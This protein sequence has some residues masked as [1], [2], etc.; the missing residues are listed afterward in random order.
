MIAS[1]RLAHVASS[2]RP[3]TDTISVVNL[4]TL[5]METHDQGYIL[6]LFVAETTGGN[7]QDDKLVNLHCKFNSG[8]K[9]GK[10]GR[11]AHDR[12]SGTLRTLILI[13][14]RRDTKRL[15]ELNYNRASKVRLDL[16]VPMCLVGRAATASATGQPTTVLTLSFGSLTLI[17]SM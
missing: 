4:P 13:R 14:H 16:Q 6:S 1:S 3:I 15:K 17:D 7:L 10:V 11:S 5:G 9:A 8:G 12:H 2:S